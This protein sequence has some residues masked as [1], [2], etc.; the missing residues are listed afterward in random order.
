MKRSYF[1]GCFVIMLFAVMSFF[2]Q[3]VYAGPPETIASDARCAV[4]GMFVT[5]YPNW[6]TQI[7]Y[8]DGSEKYFDG[9]KDLMAHFFDSAAYG[10][11]SKIEPKEIWVKDYYSLQWIPG[12]SA[13]YVM[14]SDIYGPMGEELVPFAERKSADNFLTD[15]HGKKVLTFDEITSEMVESMRAA[16]KM[17]GH[18]KGHM[19]K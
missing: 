16:H 10:T 9:V 1:P 11:D 8:S 3:P 13:F 5:K 4:C 2:S 17:K 15:H 19:M 7:R 14:G 6:V 12:R 18:M